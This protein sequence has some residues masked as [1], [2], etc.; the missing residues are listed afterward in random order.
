MKRR[1]ILSYNLVEYNLEPIL[2][3]RVSQAQREP[4]NLLVFS[5]KRKG[6]PMKFIKCVLYSVHSYP[7]V[8]STKFMI[9]NYSNCWS[10]LIALHKSVCNDSE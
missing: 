9:I 7:V 10:V 3:I 4:N 2:S 6:Q 8:I 5:K 1:S